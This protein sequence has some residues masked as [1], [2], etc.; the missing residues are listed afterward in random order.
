MEGF[1]MSTGFALETPTDVPSGDILYEVVNGQIRE[2]PPM[3]AFENSLSNY[4]HVILDSFARDHNFGRAYVEML[5]LLDSVANLQR[6]PDVAFVS[7][8]RWPKNK[9]VPKTA[10]WAIVPDLAAEVVSATNTWNEILE[11]IKDYFRTGVQLVW[12]VSPIT[13]QVYV[14]TAP[15]ANRILNKDQTLDGGDVVPGF[16]LRLVEL[17]GSEAE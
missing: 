10:A 1:A 14:Y 12:V 4:L 3:G 5:F 8:D 13:E 15:D 9:R 17:F 11:K 2:L 16:A 6:R 7:Y